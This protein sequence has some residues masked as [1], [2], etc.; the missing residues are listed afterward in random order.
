MYFPKANDKMHVNRK[1]LAELL[2][3]AVG[4]GALEAGRFTFWAAPS[5]RPPRRYPDQAILYFLRL[6]SDG[7]LQ[8]LVERGF[9]LLVFSF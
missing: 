8:G 9:V 1:V 3:A 4:T 2:V 5:L 6:A 7:P